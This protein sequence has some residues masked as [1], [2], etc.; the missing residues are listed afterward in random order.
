MIIW[1]TYICGYLEGYWKAPNW[2]CEVDLGKCD[3]AWTVKRCDGRR[4][5]ILKSIKRWQRCQKSLTQFI[6]ILFKGVSTFSQLPAIENLNR[7]IDI[8]YF[9]MPPENPFIHVFG[10]HFVTWNNEP[11]TSFTIHWRKPSSLLLA[12]LFFITP[13][14]QQEM[15]IRRSIARNLP[16]SLCVN[17]IEVI[18]LL[19]R[20]LLSFLP[21][22]SVVSF[23]FFQTIAYIFI[24]FY[25]RSQ[26]WWGLSKPKTW[27]MQRTPR[28]IFEAIQ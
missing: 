1:Y 16:L 25:V 24:W 4:R 18:V 5:K 14:I 9:D 28:I 27:W 21:M 12:S 17:V 3:R 22:F 7:K 11:R 2:L 23:L 20:H 15:G 6:P 13:P 26:N 8:Q 19:S 10:R